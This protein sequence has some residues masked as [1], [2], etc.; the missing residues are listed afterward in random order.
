MVF[1][2]GLD[3]YVLVSVFLVLGLFILVSSDLFMVILSIIIMSLGVVV[4]FFFFDNMLLGVLLLLLFLGGLMV[5]FSYSI[6]LIIKVGGSG[7]G[8]NFSFYGVVSVF[9]FFSFCSFFTT[10]LWGFYGSGVDGSVGL[11]MYFFLYFC[12]GMVFLIGVLLVSLSLC[13]ESYY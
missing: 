1:S 12:G 7:Y 13:L 4:F 10:V 6:L 2:L 3:V 8:S 9:L 11:Y 5:F